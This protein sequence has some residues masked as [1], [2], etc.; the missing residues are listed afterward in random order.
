M[1]DNPWKAMGLVSAV[2]VDLA[3]CMWAGYAAGAF[4]DQKLGNH[5][6]W[7]L[8]GLGVGLVTGIFTV[9]L[10]IKRFTGD[11]NK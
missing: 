8:I 5:M 3:V 10:L 11:D 2:G 1:N 4:V 7:S 9:I 6:L